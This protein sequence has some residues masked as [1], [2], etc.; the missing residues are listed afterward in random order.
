MMVCCKLY[1]FIIFY[2]GVMIQPT[3]EDFVEVWKTNVILL[4]YSIYMI[5][6]GESIPFIFHSLPH[7]PHRCNYNQKYNRLFNLSSTSSITI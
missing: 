1:I 5:P 6:I 4:L 7:L 3:V 2:F